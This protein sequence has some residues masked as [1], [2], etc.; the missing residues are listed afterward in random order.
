MLSMILS[1]ARSAQLLQGRFQIH[2]ARSVLPGF[3]TTLSGAWRNAECRASFAQYILQ[4]LSRHAD[5]QLRVDTRVRR[6]L[7]HHVEYLSQA[8]LSPRQPDRQQTF[9]HRDD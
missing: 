7:L 3:A 1:L 4:D 6:T 2:S 8:A 9:R 5:T